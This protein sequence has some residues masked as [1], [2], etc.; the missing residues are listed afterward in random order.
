MKLLIFDCDGTLADSQHMIVAAMDKAFASNGLAAPARHHVLGIVGLS[1]ADAIEILHPEAGHVAVHQ[2]AED[3]KLAFQELRRNAHQE[4]LYDGI[5]ELLFGLADR[6]DAVL[7]IAT[8]KSRRGVR[9]LLEREGLDSI[10]QTI[11]TA[12]THPSKPNPSMIHAAMSETGAEPSNTVMIG[13]TAYDM[14]MA[15]AAGVTGLGVAW[16]YHPPDALTAAGAAEV[17]DESQS[18]RLA[19]MRRLWSVEA[20]T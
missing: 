20:G 7:G 10:F 11:Q 9:A 16:G 13:D 3:Y 6:E 2:L 12:D 1:L 8:G 4:P 18:L 19:L 17:L 14:E 15:R 5:R